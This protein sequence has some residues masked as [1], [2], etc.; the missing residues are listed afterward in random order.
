ML[1][2]KP[3][4]GYCIF[5]SVAALASTMVF[6]QATRPSW[7][8][9]DE[10]CVG[11]HNLEDWAGQIA[12]DTVDR[13]NLHADAEIWE[14]AVRKLRSGMM[15]PAGEP[16]PARVVLDGLAQGLELAL[17]A[18]AAGNPGHKQLSRL[19]KTEYINAI[20]DLLAFDAGHIADAL[21]A[22]GS[23][24][25]FDNMA[26][27]LSMSPT[28]LEAYIGTAMEISRQAVGNT[29]IGA[30]DIH[31]YRAGRNVQD[32]HIDGQPLGTRGGMMIEHYFP[33]DAE[34]VLRISA[35]IQRAGW[36]N[37]EHRM[38]W[39]DGPAVD[40]SF[41]NTRI[42]I[43]DYRSF[44][45]SVPAG[46]Q[47][48]SVALLDD[49][50][51]AGVGELYLGEALASVGG[52]VQEI[53]I[54]GP[55]NASSPGETPSRREIF[56]CRPVATVEEAAC[57]RSILSYLATRAW[58]RLVQEDD[59]ALEPLLQQYALGRDGGN[60]ELGIQ[61]A[62]ARLL[63]D[64][65]FLYRFER[66]PGQ[67][68]AGDVYQI[69]DVE[70]ATRLSF[71]LWS[72][73][74]DEALLERAFDSSLAD[75]EV[76]AEQVRRMLADPKASALVD[77]FAG[78]WLRLRE[79]DEVAPQDA[80]FDDELRRGF[81]QETEM[82]FSDII[83]SK[84][85]MA[86][87]L[88]ADYTWLNERLARHYGIEGVSGSYMRKVKLPANSPRR[89]LLGQ[90]SIL[91]ATSIPNRT[92]PVVRGVWVVEN[93]LGAPVPDPPPGVETNL[94]GGDSV[95]GVPVADTLRGRLEQHRADPVCASC[96]GIMDPIGLALENFDKTG[97][98]RDRDNGAPIDAH[99]SMMDGTQLSGVADLRRA[100][101]SRSDTFIRTLTGKLLS[102]ALGRELEYFDGPAVRGIVNQAA[103]D[104]YTFEALVQGIVTSVPFQKRLAAGETALDGPVQTATVQQ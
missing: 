4:L 52:S 64:P 83:H 73:I 102:Y 20:R 2:C 98:W 51:C 53:E 100:L 94:D 6:A 96:H 23:L 47:Q 8:V 61:Y 95:N 46:R 63:V 104:N 74:P 84:R 24:A 27:T 79:L 5:A 90:G 54:Q 59:P 77:N 21:P 55:F 1:F 31:Y 56:R 87:L 49:K 34:Y 10:Y 93:I 37:D 57:A 44:R 91:T 35:N 3:L 12:F 14:K 86:T 15:P 97:R 66:E 43:D 60:F 48:I 16:R 25:G 82:L 71:F 32:E 45:V 65:Q 89:G 88:D 76:L 70:L 30:T 40:V 13:T 69:S 36:H 9:L 101:L 62:L 19:N 41:N 58:R 22:D 29:S 85:S 42:E 50:K 33:V 103:E 81:R 38:W 28:L 67:L 39:C 68:A 18:T 92:S 26:E 17:D 11:C 72:S 80:E 7:D 99:S 78:Q 75:P